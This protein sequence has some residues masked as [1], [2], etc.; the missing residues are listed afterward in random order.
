MQAYAERLARTCH[1]RGAQQ[2][3]RRHGPR[4]IPSRRDEAVNRIAFT[5]GARTNCAKTA[6]GFDGT[7][8][9]HPDLVSVAREAFAGHVSHAGTAFRDAA[10]RRYRRGSS[11]YGFPH[12][13]SPPPVFI[14]TSASRSNTSR[15]GSMARARSASDNLMEDTATAEISRAQLWQWRR[16]RVPI[17][18]GG[19]LTDEMYA[20]ERDRRGIRAALA[21]RWRRTPVR[22]PPR[23]LDQLVLDDTFAE[24]LTVAG[25][26]ILDRD[27]HAQ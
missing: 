24:F 22:R 6:R 26:S 8:I 9:A 20:K 12:Q 5:K 16:H 27:A 15:R 25:A 14:P 23:L 10:R 21:R 7:W 4:F 18:G 17:G 13:A 11:T 19:P 3:N 1:W 2:A